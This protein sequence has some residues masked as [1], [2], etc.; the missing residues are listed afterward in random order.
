M[1]IDTIKYFQIKGDITE[2]KAIQE[3][4]MQVVQVQIQEI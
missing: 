3:E 4:E 1:L 2:A